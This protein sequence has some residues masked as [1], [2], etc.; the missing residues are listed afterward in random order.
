M[1]SVA[2]RGF[3]DAKVGCRAQ[4]GGLK[5]IPCKFFLLRSVIGREN[6]RMT[7]LS[8]SLKPHP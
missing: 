1:L 5:C 4:Y 7:A 3:P 8:D 6:R 2:A